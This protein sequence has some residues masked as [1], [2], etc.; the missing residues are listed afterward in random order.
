MIIKI[1]DFSPINH[2]TRLQII[3]EYMEQF[4]EIKL[5][6]N[7]WCNSFQYEYNIK[8]TSKYPVKIQVGYR[9]YHVKCKKTKTSLVFNIWLAP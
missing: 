4:E 5:T 3:E 9:N 2:K 8:E 6:N 1:N 7:G